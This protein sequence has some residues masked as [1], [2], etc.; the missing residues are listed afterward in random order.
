MRQA[1][2]EQRELRA[3]TAELGP[4]SPLLLLG[5]SSRRAAV[6]TEVA[7]GRGCRGHAGIPVETEEP[8]PRSPSCPVALL[9]LSWVSALPCYP[10]K[11]PP[12]LGK[13]CHIPWGRR[14]WRCSLTPDLAMNTV[15]GEGRVCALLVY[16]CKRA[17]VF[18]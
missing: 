13:T 12:G 5:P 10:F 4:A 1:G 16:V 14:R 6:S 17:S 2:L 15:V 3:C 18:V 9:L 11:V 7:L 8:V